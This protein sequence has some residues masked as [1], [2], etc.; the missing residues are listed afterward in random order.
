[1]LVILLKDVPGAGRAGEVKNVSDGY[2]KNFLLPRSLAAA[3]TPARLN[4]RDA[5]MAAARQK[6]ERDKAAFRA[7]AGTLPK[8][9]LRFTMNMGKAGHAFGSVTAENIATAF[10]A[11]GIEIEKQWIRLDGHIKTAGEHRVAIHLPHDIRSEAVL[12]VENKNG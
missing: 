10:R 6:A 4:E 12:I 11:Q 3:A 1:M 5:R 2:A 7:L 9:T 8:T